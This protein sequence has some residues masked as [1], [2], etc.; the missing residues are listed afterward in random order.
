[1]KYVN[2]DL[3]MGTELFLNSRI[4]YNVLL[5]STTLLL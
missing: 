3:L 5:H 2:N 4:L 1:M